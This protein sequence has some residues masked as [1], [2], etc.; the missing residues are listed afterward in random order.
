[1]LKCR[2]GCLV[3]SF[4]RM[5]AEANEFITSPLTLDMWGL[6][7][8]SCTW[9]HFWD[10]WLHGQERN[11]I[12]YYCCVLLSSHPSHPLT[13][14]YRGVV[15]ISVPDPYFSPQDHVC[16]NWWIQAFHSSSI[17]QTSH[18]LHHILLDKFMIGI[19]YVETSPIP[20]LWVRG[21]WKFLF[22]NFHIMCA[23]TDSG[24]SQQLNPSNFNVS[25]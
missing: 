1:M 14:E 21:W 23:C 10:R 15:I 19:H 6:L 4:W 13:Y 12:Y 9:S 18:H 7:P 20:D 3:S 8:V 11:T 24:I 5:M 16:L 25:I 2:S 22:P 17:L